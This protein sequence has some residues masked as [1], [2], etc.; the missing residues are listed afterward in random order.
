MRFLTA[1]CSFVLLAPLAAR[2]ETLAAFD[3]RCIPVGCVAPRSNTPGILGRRALPAGRLARLGATPEFHHGLLVFAVQQAP[4]GQSEYV[5]IK[6]LPPTDQMPAA[7]LLI[8]AYAFV[9]IAV[10][11]YLWT[12]WRRLN[13]VEAEMGALAKKTAGR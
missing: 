4:P 6:D 7:P 12:I 3:G 11:F 2:G 8:A 5:P 13:R 9:W 1:L 10:M